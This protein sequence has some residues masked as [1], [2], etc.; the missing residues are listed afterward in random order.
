MICKT[1]PFGQV[2]V[3][4]C[5]P[6]LPALRYLNCIT[7]V[8]WHNC[9]S[10]YRTEY[11]D[12]IHELFVIYTVKGAGT[13]E[14]EKGS[15]ALCPDSLIFVPP[16]TPMKYFTDK[17]VGFWEFYWV[18]LT[19][20][21]I[22]S[23]AERLCRDGYGY[24]RELSSCERIFEELLAEPF[25]EVKGSALIGDLFDK[26]ISEAVFEE[27][28]SA[29]NQILKYLSEHYAERVD[30][31]HMSELFY[32]SQNQIIRI[33]RNRTGYTPHEY[34]TRLRLTK[35]CELLQYTAMPVGEIGRVIGYGNNSHFSAAFRR[36][37]GI[38]PAEYRSRFS[39]Q[40]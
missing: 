23:L 7:M 5:V 10:A 34:L 21:R 18:D 35:A 3:T 12:G 6:T 22:L 8:G 9:N 2:R 39:E 32:F 26:V 31:R 20:E 30:L 25:S 24:L 4:S 29:A 15:F 38:S 17:Q 40:R 13:L 33:V 16:H 37:Y 19:G 1:I 36:L 11:K 14:T 28:L 27:R